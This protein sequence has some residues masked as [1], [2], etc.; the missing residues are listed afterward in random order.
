M[1]VNHA[2]RA[3]RR[4]ILLARKLKQTIEDIHARNA[5]ADPNEIQRIVDEAV[6]EVRAERHAKRQAARPAGTRR[7]RRRS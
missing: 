5:G 6:R 3:E 2:R 4:R 1:T 7:R